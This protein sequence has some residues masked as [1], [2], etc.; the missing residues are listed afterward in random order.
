M[1]GCRKANPKNRKTPSSETERGSF[2][3][4]T[5]TK[6]LKIAK[7]RFL[8]NICEGKFENRGFSNATPAAEGTERSDRVGFYRCPTRGS[9][10]ACGEVEA[11]N[12]VNLR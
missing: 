8:K 9:G 4:G 12:P 10:V 6:N 7:R 11:I 5:E 3:F 2:V 1:L